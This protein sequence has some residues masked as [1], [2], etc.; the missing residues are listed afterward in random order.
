MVKVKKSFVAFLLMLLFSA[1][2]YAE[3]PV[4]TT[5]FYTKSGGA[6]SSLI[7]KVGYGYMYVPS[8]DKTE[9]EDYILL[10][11]HVVCSGPGDVNCS[12]KPYT[13]SSTG[14]IHLDILSQ[15]EVELMS[16]VDDSL[17]N[18][19]YNG[20]TSKKVST[21]ESDGSHKV[22][23]MSMRWENGSSDGSCRAVLVIED[24]TDTL[25]LPY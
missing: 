10:D 2:V 16:V 5:V 25:N 12:Y 23:L 15:Y 22:W 17:A 1:A 3:K 11:Y 19:V 6:W 4:N 9:T 7:N 18:G 8:P 24:I 21:L 13:T 14:Y 20:V